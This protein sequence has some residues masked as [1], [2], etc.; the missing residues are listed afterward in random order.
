MIKIGFIGLGHMGMPMAKG[1]M[2]NGYEVLAYDQSAT[3][4]ADYQALGGKTAISLQALAQEVNCVITMLPNAAILNQVYLELFNAVSANT[5][6]IDC[7][8]VGPMAARQWHSLAKSHGLRSVDAPVSG[9]VSAASQGS[10]SFMMGG[11]LQAVHDAKEILQALGKK[12]IYTG[13]E[14][15]GQAAKICNNLVLANT[16]IAV[17][18]AFALASALEL[19]AKALHEVLSTS[20]GNS[21]VIENYLPVP[22]INDSVPANRDYQPGFRGDMML[23]DIKLA[24]Q[25]AQAHQLA[26]A[27]TQT[28]EQQYQA[29]IDQGFG[30]KDFSFIYQLL[31]Q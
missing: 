30:D 1:L 8:T 22:K 13:G 18:E 7:S 26:L 28:S 25:A 24:S 6:L 4:M 20:S 5:I 3:A 11:E 31:A 10:L 17:S 19:D 15:S 16:M 23:K 2:Q 12:F 29:M 27:L 21:W 14:G 9:G